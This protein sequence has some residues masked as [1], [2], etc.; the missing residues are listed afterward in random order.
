MSV[1]AQGTWPALD[2]LVDGL[3][4]ADVAADVD[5]LAADPFEMQD[6]FRVPPGRNNH[7]D[8][9]RE[10]LG[11]PEG[12]IGL[13]ARFLISEPVDSLDDNNNLLVNLLRAVN[14]LLLLYL[15]TDDIQPVSEKLPDVLLE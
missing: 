7:L 6:A 2:V 5:D 15:R 14:D 11:Q 13:S 4:D 3:S 10:P 9:L 12:D 8:V 1:R